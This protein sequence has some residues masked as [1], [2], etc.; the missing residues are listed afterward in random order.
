MRLATTR[1][2]ARGL[3]MELVVLSHFCLPFEVSCWS[4]CRTQRVTGFVVGLLRH[5]PRVLQR[6]PHDEGKLHSEGLTM[7][8]LTFRI[9]AQAV[10][11][12]GAEL[13][14]NWKRHH[15]YASEELGLKL[16][17]KMYIIQPFIGWSPYLPCREETFGY[18]NVSSEG[19]QHRLWRG[20]KSLN[21]CMCRST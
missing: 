10:V 17:R 8:L 7:P 6:T 4:A 2:V 11:W 18:R 14:R 3:S 21:Q 20:R 19:V 16:K 5:M 1:L 12:K 15:N 13:C 9:Q